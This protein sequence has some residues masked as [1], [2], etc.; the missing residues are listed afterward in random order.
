I[1]PNYE[2]LEASTQKVA[3][4]FAEKTPGKYEIPQKV[5]WAE[6]GLQVV[7]QNDALAYRL[8]GKKI[9]G[10]PHYS[11]PVCIRNR[12]LFFTKDEIQVAENGQIIQTQKIDFSRISVGDLGFYPYTAWI[13][14][15]DK[16]NDHWVYSYSYQQ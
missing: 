12:V 11:L 9:D 16:L 13:N 7:Y 5:L 14:I 1:E 10:A 6:N 4:F 15:G 2:D 3:T 8:N